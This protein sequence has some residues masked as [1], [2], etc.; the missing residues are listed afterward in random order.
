MEL[1]DKAVTAARKEGDKKFGKFSQEQI[2]AI[3]SKAK[4]NLFFLAYGLLGYDKLS[5]KF[6]GDLC[7]WL[8]LTTNDLYREILLPRSHYKSTI[9]TISDSIQIVLPDD[10]GTAA[11][12]RN[13]GTNARLL[14]AHETSDAAS[15][16]L[17]SITQHFTGN[18]TLL[19]F[20][21]EC[22][23]QKGARLNKNEL[24]LP[25]T[26][27]WSEP[28]FDT[29]GVGGKAQGR[30]YNYIKPDDI[31]GSAARDSKAERDTTISWIDNLQSLLITPRTDHIDFVGTRWAFDDAYAHIHKTY[32]SRLK[33]YIRSCEEFDETL[34][35]KVPIFPEEFTTESLEILKKNRQV[36]NAQYAN[37]P[38]E[39][40]AAFQS[41]WLR[42]Y[43]WTGPRKISLID[44]ELH[45]PLDVGDLDKIILIDPAM[46]GQAG[47]IVTGTDHRNRIVTLEAEKRSWKPP[48][49]IEKIFQSVIRWQP[50]LVAIEEV[51][52][53]GLFQHWLQREMSVRGISFKLEPVKTGQKSKET[54]VHGLSNYFSA[55]QIYFNE[56]QTELIEEFKQFGASEDYH[57]LDALAYGPRFWRASNNQNKVN[58]YRDAERALLES[59]DPLTGYSD[60]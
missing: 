14:I 40:A 21:P 39:G 11:Y 44:G 54:R 9:V 35:K 50:R 6:H 33:K 1:N 47:F 19:F 49:L 56:S 42:Y 5:K 53:S 51:L 31:Y 10:L 15:R 41:E 22:I 13:L 16:F 20:F 8:D 52:F 43:K 48:E 18:P 60:Y 59:R 25:R 12:P 2:N 30:H 4:H 58:M 7:R 26:Q 38:A 32:G 23:P 24:E 34:Q 28:T 57:M 55:G 29:I 27:I 45:T 37:N 3:R 46:M 17:Q 36:W